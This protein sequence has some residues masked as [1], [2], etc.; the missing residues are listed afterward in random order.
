MMSAPEKQPIWKTVRLGT[1]FT[2]PSEFIKAITQ[3]GMRVHM[4]AIA[5]MERPLFIPYEREIEVELVVKTGYELGFTGK[6]V[7]RPHVLTRARELGLALCPAEV[8][9][10]LR[11]QYP[12]QPEGEGL[13]IGMEP[14]GADFGYAVTFDVSHANGDRW[15]SV[16]FLHDPDCRDL[17]ESRYVF[18]R[19]R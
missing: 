10:Q 3:S 1:G 5:P 13:V 11:L 9:P 8:G 7:A 18:V 12:N 4:F 19:S 14:T 6:L 17:V 15:L 16:D 2:S